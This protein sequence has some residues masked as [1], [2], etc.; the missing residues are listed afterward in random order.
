MTQEPLS[1][2]R[3]LIATIRN[4]ARCKRQRALH[5]VA[6]HPAGELFLSIE[7]DIHQQVNTSSKQSTAESRFNG[8][9]RRGD[10]LFL[11]A[12]WWNRCACSTLQFYAVLN[13][14][15][16][17]GVEQKNDST[18]TLPSSWAGLSLTAMPWLVPRTC[19]NPKTRDNPQRISN[20]I[21]A[22]KSTDTV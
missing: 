19:G 22:F 6:T 4:A 21:D 17:N 12:Y 8:C 2:N 3:W 9:E 10:L 5:A 18:P 11:I 20:I 14:A 1:S 13:Y 7:H 15:V 16:L